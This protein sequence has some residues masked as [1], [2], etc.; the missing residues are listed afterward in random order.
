MRCGSRSVT[1]VLT[2]LI[3]PLAMTGVA[4]ALFRDKA[5]GSLVRDD[6]GN[7]GRLGAHRPDL[8]QPR[9]PAGSPVGGRQRLRRDG[10][11]GVEPGA[12]VEEAARPRGGRLLYT[13][14]L[15]SFAAFRVLLLWLVTAK[16]I[17]TLIAISIVAEPITSQLVPS[18]DW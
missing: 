17:Y 15:S 5:N 9:L 11:V 3:Y 18:A 13:L 6:E 10:V 12:D 7:G 14:T 16:P 2:G 4:Q 8:R 1:L